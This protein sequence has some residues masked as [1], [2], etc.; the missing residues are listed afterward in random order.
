MKLPAEGGSS[1]MRNFW[2]VDFFSAALDPLL[3]LGDARWMAAMKRVAFDPVRSR[4]FGEPGNVDSCL[5]KLQRQGRQSR[6][7]LD[8][9]AFCRVRRFCQVSDRCLLS[10]RLIEEA[11]RLARL[12]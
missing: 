2:V 7:P 5:R 9:A 1:G 12:Q 3:I 11:G 10:G 6:A 4:H 8:E